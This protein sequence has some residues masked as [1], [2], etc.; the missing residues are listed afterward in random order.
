MK[1]TKNYE[2][3]GL[4]AFLTDAVIVDLR[5]VRGLGI[6]PTRMEIEILR[7]GEHFVMEAE[8]NFRVLCDGRAILCFDDLFLNKKHREMSPKTFRAQ[9]GIENSLLCEN[10]ALTLEKIRG[11]KIRKIRISPCG[12][13]EI[14]VSRNTKLQ[15][16]NDTHLADSCVFRLVTKD[17]TGVFMAENGKTYPIAETLFE[18]VNGNRND[19]LFRNALKKEEQPG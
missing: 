1:Q 13:V 11:K 4:C 2:T 15:I 18:M 16:L 19:L 14:C 9:S 17:K 8:T 12:D 7:E 6:V 5:A 3:A 10:I